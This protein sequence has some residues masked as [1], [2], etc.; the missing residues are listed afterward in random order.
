IRRYHYNSRDLFTAGSYTF[1]NDET[2]L[3]GFAS[4]TG[5]TYAS[6]LL[7]TVDSAG[8]RIPVTFQ[9]QRM[10]YSAVYF[11]DDWKVR[12]NLTLNLG[13]RW[14]IPGPLGEVADRM[15]SLDPKKPNPG[16]DG[17]P[18]ALAFLGDC[19]GC[20][21]RQSFQDHYFKEFGPRFGFA[22][23]PKLKLVVRGGYGI[24]YSAPLQN[25]W[26]YDLDAGFNG[27]N[28]IN[29]NSGRFRQDPSLY[30]DAG[31]SPYTKPLPNYDPTLVNGADISYLGVDTIRQ[32]Y[33]QNWTFGIQY[34]LPWN[35]AFEAN[36]I[37]NKGTLPVNDFFKG[38]L[39]QGDPK[40][41]VLGDAIYDYIS[42]HP[43]IPKPYL[44]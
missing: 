35:T 9:G 1:R 3:P 23:S 31:Y 39:N 25:G 14:E 21:G 34:E 43:N 6:F 17:H 27:S 11:Q 41:L 13:L 37:G 16:A 33:T 2:A 38:Y 18:G 36:Y 29:A 28:P 40:Y 10:W 32:P 22:W 8:L 7:G 4:S 15:S 42:A 12:P 5:F 30:W 26:G 19:Q 20:T 24:N 44:R